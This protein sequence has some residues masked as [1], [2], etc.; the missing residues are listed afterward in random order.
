MNPS[1][2]SQTR[3]G[4]LAWCAACAAMLAAQLAI[5]LFGISRGFWLDEAWVAN[6]VH[7]AT[8]GGMFYYPEWLQTSPP[9]FLLAARVVTHAA[10]FTEVTLRALP[11]ALSLVALA[12]ILAAARRVL[13]AGLAILAGALVAFSQIAIE[14]SHTFKQYSGELAVSAILLWLVIRYVQEPSRIHFVHLA[15]G[16][17]VGLT[18]AYPAAFLIPGILFAVRNRPRRVL[19]IGV[20]A[21]AVLGLLYVALIRPNTSPELWT[22]WNASDETALRPSSVLYLLGLAAAA[23]PLLRRADPRRAIRIF[24]V[25]PCALL[26]IAGAAGIYPVSPRTQLFAT[27]LFWVALLLVAEEWLV[28]FPKAIQAVGVA[29]A[30]MVILSSMTRE[31]RERRDEPAENLQPAMA[32]LRQHVQPDDL[33]LIHA[34]EREGFR[35]EEAVHGWQGPSPQFGDTGW[36]C[37]PRGKNAQ[38][39]NSR[40]AS[41]IEEVQRLIPAGYRGRVWLFYTN[42]PSHWTYTGLDEGDQWRKILWEQGCPPDDQGGW[43]AIGLSLMDCWQ[44]SAASRN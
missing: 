6:S 3:S 31:I 28:W 15:V 4:I 1:K 40:L 41:V 38:P 36:P 33:V 12:T 8:L 27:P 13:S 2:N 5:G 30:A 39:G 21:V 24:C 23:I 29:L 43:S 18:L 14:Y 10:G 25:L 19:V 32:F 35:F 20:T 22:F 44:K 9:L 26:A 7:S 16:I 17:G 34:S 11:L 37:C 42:R